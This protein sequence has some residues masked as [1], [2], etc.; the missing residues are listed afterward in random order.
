MADPFVPSDLTRIVLAGDPQLARDGAVYYRRATFDVEADEIV[1]TIRRIAR[2]GSERAFT[3]GRNDRLPRVAPDGSALA[4]V[5]DRDEKAR[6]FTLALDGG[7]AQQLGDGWTKIVALAWSPDA[8]RLAIVAAAEHDASSAPIYH[9]AKTGARHIRR[10]PFKSDADGMLDGV[11]KHLYVADVAAGTLRQVTHGDFDVNAPSWS[12]D[13]SRIAFHA[14]IGIAEDATSLSDVYAV[15][16]ES[17]ELSRL[18]HGEGPMQNPVFS[19][20]GREIAFLGHLHGDDAGG[21]FDTELLVV[22]SE[23]GPIRSL[24]A[25]LNR[26]V[27][28]AL[29]GDLR[30]GASSPPAWSAGDREIVVQVCDEGTT[31]IRAF[32]RDGGAVRTLAGG[33]RQIFQF[34]LGDDGALAIAY[35][36]PT[37]PNEIALIEPYG[38]ER[39]LTD[40][41]PWLREKHVAA[42]VRFRPPASDGTVLDGWL[43]RPQQQRP[44]GPLVL[45]VHG[46]PHGAYGF[47]FFFEFQV[48]AAQGIAVAYGNPRGSQS[49]GAAYADAILGDWGGVDADDVLRILDG[50]LAQ[51]AYDTG[52][53][54]LAGG[55]YGGFMTTWL[56]GHSD[57]FAAG[58]S[59][60]AVN[61]FV[62]EIGA[63]DLG[64]FLERELQTRYADDAG[65]KLF[66]ASPMRAAHA[67]D[68]PLLVEHSERDYRCPIDNG[69][70]LF[71]ILRRLGKHHCEF[72][73]FTDT[74]H[75]MSRAGKP[76]SRV[77]R[78]RA[79]ANWFVRHLNPNGATVAN[80]EAGWVFRPLAHEDDVLARD[81]ASPAASREREPAGVSG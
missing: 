45:E 33:A 64:W 69:E 39:T 61:D 58:V 10:L 14:R 18:T 44:H 8:R 27:G 38:G 4:F 78:L 1:G 79:I 6:A 43:L 48:L 73:R 17:G 63:S 54:G 52:R 30:S 77:L 36:S 16:V 32:A 75:E 25:S 15:A 2:D 47:T 71:T 53:I 28:D 34:C 46:G 80:D 31:S 3:S 81:G 13:G 50:A 76:R 23:G 12:P 5:A 11:R 65:R 67:I 72:V 68:A 51:D 57:R 49:Y 35:S 41:N 20:D 59:M 37:V 21:R 22:P 55:S 29:A 56:L 62:S 60:R 26:T 40:A 9:D 66:E 70:Q 24:S 74:G 42:P 7:E 19:H